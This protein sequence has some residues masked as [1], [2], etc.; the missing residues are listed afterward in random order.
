MKSIFVS[1]LKKS[2]NEFFARWYSFLLTYTGQTISSPLESFLTSGYTFITA[3]GINALLWSVTSCH[4]HTTFIHIWYSKINNLIWVLS[5]WAYQFYCMQQTRTDTTSDSNTMW[6]KYR[7]HLSFN[8]YVLSIHVCFTVP[9]DF[10]Q[11]GGKPH[12]HWAFATGLGIN[13]LFAI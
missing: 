9:K 7:I 8:Q 2:M 11:N 6:K 3:Y 13:C 10:Q 1:H 5:L 4:T 12:F